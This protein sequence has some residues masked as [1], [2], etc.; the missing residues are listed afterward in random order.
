ME[1][2]TNRFG[3]NQTAFA[4][5]IK[6]APSQVNHWITGHRSLGDAGARHIEIELG[7]EQGFFDRSHHRSNSNEYTEKALTDPRQT[8]MLRDRSYDYVVEADHM[9]MFIEMKRRPGSQEQET[10]LSSVTQ[11]LISMLISL[12]H[13]REGESVLGAIFTLLSSSRALEKRT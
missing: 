11:K 1:L 8:T 9:V 4:K 3:G 5:A 13:S 2:V 6:K 10:R 12:E 7:L